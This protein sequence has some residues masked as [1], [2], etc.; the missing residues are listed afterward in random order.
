MKMATGS[1]KIITLQS[2]CTTKE[3]KLALL[4]QRQ[5]MNGI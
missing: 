4:A 5:I 1:R 2:W 3:S